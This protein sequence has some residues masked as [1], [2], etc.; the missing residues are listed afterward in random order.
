MT[1]RKAL[2]CAGA[3]LAIAAGGAG[4]QSPS[5]SLGLPWDGSLAGGVRLAAESEHHFTWDPV[6]KRSPNRGWRR[7]GNA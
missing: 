1:V 6:R 2:L 7:Y 3:A 5:R 4:A